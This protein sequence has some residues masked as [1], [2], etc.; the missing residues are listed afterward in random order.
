MCHIPASV[1]AHSVLPTAAT[2]LT[3]PGHRSHCHCEEADSG[4]GDH[5][6]A[7]PLKPTAHLPP[8]VAE[9]TSASRRPPGSVATWAGGR[10]GCIVPSRNTKPEHPASVPSGHE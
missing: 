8:P 10:K 3:G 5:A 6:S 2:A 7:S 4:H 1:A 9:C